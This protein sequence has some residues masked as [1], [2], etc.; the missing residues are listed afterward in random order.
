ML[1]SLKSRHHFKHLSNDLSL[2]VSLVRSIWAIR[3]ITCWRGTWGSGCSGAWRLGVVLV[4]AIC[5]TERISYEHFYNILSARG[6]IG[7]LVSVICRCW[8]GSSFTLLFVCSVAT[9]W[10]VASG[11]CGW[12]SGRRRCWGIILVLSVFSVVPAYL[13][14]NGCARNSKEQCKFTRHRVP[15]AHVTEEKMK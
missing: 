2:S 5:T 14:S 6:R 13:V 8:L 11:C 4:R 15:E 3:A 7:S 1:V 12:S 9:I 10:S